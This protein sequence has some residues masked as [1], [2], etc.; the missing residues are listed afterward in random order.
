MPASPE[1]IRDLAREM[2]GR[3][4]EGIRSLRRLVE[5]PPFQAAIQLLCRARGRVLAC[6]VGKSGL[7]AQRIAASFRSTGTPSFFLHPVEAVHGD[8]GLIEPD[9]VGLFLSKSGESEELLRLLPSFARLGVPLLAATARADSPLARAAALHLMVGPLEEAGP[10]R[11]VP[12]TSITVF[13]VLGNLLV[14]AVYTARGISEEDLAWLHPGGLI[15]GMVS[16]R[17]EALMHTGEAIPR[18]TPEAFLRE[19]I[20]EMMSKRL[21][22]TTVVDGEGRLLGLVTDG[23]VRRAVHAHERIDPLRVADVMTRSPRTIGRE[24]SIA[25]AVEQMERNRPGPITALVVTDD[26]GM[27]EGVLHLHDC[28][29]LRRAG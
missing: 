1:A 21:G 6:G 20:V 19:A 8:L 9:D 24:A 29:R 3:E 13:E 2:L 17:V 25:T 28:L 5:E 11:A 18:V 16:H 12:S 4:E 23:D 10:I 26:A 22:L 15:G 7:V 27:V 14:A